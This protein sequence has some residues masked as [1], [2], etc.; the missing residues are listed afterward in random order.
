MREENS[1]FLMSPSVRMTISFTLLFLAVLLP[2]TRQSQAAIIYP[3]G[4]RILQPR[5]TIN[6]VRPITAPQEVLIKFRPGV[7]NNQILAVLIRYQL[8]E[9]SFSPYSG[10]RRCLLPAQIPINQAVSSLRAEPSILYAEP[11]WLGY[12]H[13]IPNDPFLPYQWH[14]PMMNIN[15]AWDISI[16]GGVVV[17]ELDTGVS[18]ENF[19]IYGLAPDLAGTSFVPGYDFVNDDPNPDDDEGHGTHIAGTIAQTTGNGLGCAGGAFGATIMPVKVMDSTGSGTLTDIVDGIYY[20]ANNGAKIINM[21][22]GFGDNPTLALED[23]VNYAYDSGCLLICSAGNAGTNTPN[24]PASYPACIS[25][26]GVRYDLTLGSYSNYGLD[27]D[28]CAPGG[29]LTLDQNLDGYPDGILQ[30]SHD[31]TNFTNFGFYMG[32]GTSWAAANVTAVAALVISASGGILAPADVRSILE[33]TARD[34][35]TAG[36][37][38]YFGWGL[39]DA[40]AAVNAAVAAAASAQVLGA[41]IPFTLRAPATSLLTAAAPW[42]SANSLANRQWQLQQALQQGIQQAGQWPWQVNQQQGGWGI[43]SGTSSAAARFEASSSL[44]AAQILGLSDWLFPL[45]MTGVGGLT[46]AG[47]GSLFLNSA[48]SQSQNQSRS[49]SASQ[50]WGSQGIF[51]PLSWSPLSWPLGYSA[52]QSYQAIDSIFWP[53]APGQGLALIPAQGYARLF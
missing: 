34:L 2:A 6:G 30:Q 10:I 39:V 20:A 48:G 7:I 38:E 33:T 24:Y 47:A 5:Y 19:D 53:L 3:Y 49:S 29:D 37:D 22:L 41:R 43:S 46:N 4:I 26:S 12:A 21:S 45:S 23:A 52:A 36:W 51:S 13:L 35:G 28:L 18:F 17:A 44:A 15:A 11:N 14:L 9:I 50:L 1:A 31:G 16:G 40:Y 32:R 27:I 25:V 42:I 8:T